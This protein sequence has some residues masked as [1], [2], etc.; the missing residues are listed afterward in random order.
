MEKVS[1]LLT[2]SITPD[3]DLFEVAEE[4]ESWPL[5]GG[6]SKSRLFFESEV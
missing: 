2:S 4:T 5:G 3:Y 6:K 1:S